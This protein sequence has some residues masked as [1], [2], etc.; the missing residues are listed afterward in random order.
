M[1]SRITVRHL[2]TFSTHCG[3][4]EAQTGCTSAF[5]GSEFAPGHYLFWTHHELRD[6]RRCTRSSLS[7]ATRKAERRSL[8]E[9]YYSFPH[10]GK[11]CGR[12]AMNW[13]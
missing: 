11:I 5:D 8:I 2:L 4:K 10:R 6:D 7:V 12:Y 3:V 9:R 13:N 1:S